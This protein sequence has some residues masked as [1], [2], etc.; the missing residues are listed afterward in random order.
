M[1]KKITFIFVLLA[2]LFIFSQNASRIDSLLKAVQEYPKQDTIKAR[3]YYL[4][5]RE[6]YNPQNY[7]LA[8]VYFFRSYKL[9]LSNGDF[10]NAAN[11]LEKISYLY[12]DANKLDKALF[13]AFESFKLSK[14]ISDTHQRVISECDAYYCLAQ[15]Y[16]A[17]DNNLSKH[18][19]H[20]CLILSKEITNEPFYHIYNGL[21]N[22]YVK[23]S[24]KLVKKD[25]IL[26]IDSVSDPPR[27]YQLVDSALH[28]YKLAL[29]NMEQYHLIEKEPLSVLTIYSN[30]GTIYLKKNETKKSLEYFF[31]AI[32]IAEKENSI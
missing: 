14:R 1:V 7:N 18:Y 32:N 3:L 4:I 15:I 25:P 13:Y 12:L 6:Y 9:Y 10:F 2:S 8:I 20:R 5:G 16:D 26:K 24:E 23:E 31:K 27:F 28:F 19:Y 11:Q 22:V 30:I 21:G 17:D 29:T